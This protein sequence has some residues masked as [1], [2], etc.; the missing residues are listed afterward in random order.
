MY[1]EQPCVTETRISNKVGSLFQCRFPSALVGGL[2]R[3]RYHGAGRLGY[4]NFPYM[5]SKHSAHAGEC[6]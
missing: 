4:L 1:D 5:R 6:R 2:T 3:K